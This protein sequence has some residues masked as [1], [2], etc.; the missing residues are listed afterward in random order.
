MI[1]KTPYGNSPSIEI[2]IANAFVD[3]NTIN[4]IEIHLEE[5]RHDMVVLEMY[6]IPPRAITDYYN[7]PVTIEVSNGG[8]F[9]HK[10]YGYVEDVRPSSFTGHGLM[11]DSPFQTAQIVCMGTSYNMRGSTSKVWNGY[12]LSDITKE[13]AAKYRFSADVPEDNYVH[14]N[15]LQ[16]N[17]SDWQFLTRYAN[18]LGYAVNVHGTHVHVYDA[19][20]ALSR[21]TSY[22]QLT[23]LVKGKGRI[24]VHPG[25]IIDFS[26]T[27]SKR[28]I[29]GEYKE[30]TIPVLNPDLSMY[31][32]SSTQLEVA[33]NGVARFPNRIPEYVDN[34]EEATRR[35][36]ALSKDKYD[37]YAD[38]T[39]LGVPGC[40]PGG[41]VNIDSYT[42]DFDGFWYVSGVKHVIHSDAFYSE[43]NIAK[44]FN[45]ELRFTNTEPF[46]APADPY[47]DRD[48][49]VSSKAVTHEYS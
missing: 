1:R 15:L 16:T 28:H 17:E 33:H 45:S 14:D 12:K 24:N 9:Y 39:V 47:F 7:K 48:T 20:T 43:L 46:Q 42:S 23:P 40:L 10:F 5:N 35:I 3:Y 26:G 34:Y 4:L 44:N 31:D 30:S 21:Q 41:V 18:F 8:N 19:Y 22:H 2:V 36:N 6:G 27:F 49:W 38:V 32:V 13:L 11:N 37:Y 25:Q 29:D